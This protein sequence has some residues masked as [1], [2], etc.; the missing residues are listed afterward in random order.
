MTNIAYKVL[1]YMYSCQIRLPDGTKYLPL[2]QAE[3]APLIGVSTININKIFKHK[4]QCEK[5][6]KPSVEEAY[7]DFEDKE[8]NEEIEAFAKEKDMIKGQI[9]MA[10]PF[11]ERRALIQAI[12]DFIIQKL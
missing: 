1:K 6:I 12:M 9:P 5:D 8:R 10:L 3:M 4:K 11:R 2:S 7:V